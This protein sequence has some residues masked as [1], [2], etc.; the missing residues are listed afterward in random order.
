[1][2]NTQEQIKNII[3]KLCCRCYDLGKNDGTLED[4]DNLI[5]EELEEKT[6]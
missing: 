5:K 2:K 4:L 3:A 1:M 6:Q